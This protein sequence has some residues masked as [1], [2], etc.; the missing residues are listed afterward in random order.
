MS[1]LVATTE[2][3][4]ITRPFTVSLSLFEFAG[5]ADRYVYELELNGIPAD[6]DGDWSVTVNTDSRSDIIRNIFSYRDDDGSMT[7]SDSFFTDKTNADSLFI[8]VTL[9]AYS[10]KYNIGVINTDVTVGGSVSKTVYYYNREEISEISHFPSNDT[11]SQVFVNGTRIPVVNADVHIRKEGALDVTRYAEVQFPAVYENKKYNQLFSTVNPHTQNSFDTLYIK[12]KDGTGNFVPVFRGYVTGVGSTD[13]NRVW[14]LRARGPADLLNSVNVGKQFTSTTGAEV[15]KYIIRRLRDKL[16]FDFKYPSDENDDVLDELEIFDANNPLGSLLGLEAEGQDL[17][18][19]TFQKNRHTL[20]DVVDWLRSKSALRLWFEPTE[21]G[22]VFLPFKQPTAKSHKAH[23]LGGN[24]K[25]IENNALSELAPINTIEARGSA[26][27]TWLSIGDFDLNTGGDK[28]V[29]AKARHK[30]LYKRAGN[31]ELKADTFIEAEGNTKPEVK[32]DARSALKERIDE[33]TAGDMMTLL[34][35]GVT[36]FDTIEA[37]PTCRTEAEETV[38]ITYEVNRVHH[39]VS[40]EDEES[41]NISKSRLNIGIHTDM[42]D[43]IEIKDK[44]VN[45]VDKES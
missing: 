33:A 43:D 36:P 23:Y 34:A 15:A 41:G 3:T 32:N 12:L 42:Q 5:D 9:D 4:P 16:P 45:K 40:P 38:P 8:N 10:G 2:N 31:T 20:K 7:Y 30:D 1:E 18:N 24:V 35:G 6:V 11:D 37:R 19:K 28:F 44:W 29:I 27:K 26:T 21:E 17:S 14:Q 13:S 25:V 39:M 22:V